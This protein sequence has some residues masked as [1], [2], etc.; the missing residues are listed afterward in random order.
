MFWSHDLLG[1]KTALGAIWIAAHGKKLNKNNIL[2]VNVAEACNKVMDPEVPQ[3]LRL[4]A[5]LVGGIVIVHARQQVYLLE[6]AQEMLRR[7]RTLDS[8][9][10]GGVGAAPR[11]VLKEG[12]RAAREEAITLPLNA[13][14]G[15]MNLG[16]LFPT[17][18]TQALSE[19]GASGA[20]RQ[21]SGDLFVMPSLPD[22]P[23][24]SS[25]APSHQQ[26]RGRSRDAA[27]QHGSGGAG[28]SGARGGGLL[29][30]GADEPDSQ[31]EGLGRY[32]L[33]LMDG[34][35]TFAVPDLDLPGMEMFQLPAHLKGRGGAAP[36]S[37]GGGAEPKP[38]LTDEL[39]PVPSALLG[40]EGF[41]PEGQP[42]VEQ[43]QLPPASQTPQTSEDRSAGARGAAAGARQRGRGAK[44]GRGGPK[45][46]KATVDDIETLQIR[47]WE[48][49]EWMADH[50]DLL[51]PRPLRSLGSAPAG[52]A[53]KAALVA[54][55]ATAAYLP[56]G[57]WPQ[58]LCELFARV[59]TIPTA[60]GKARVKQGKGRAAPGEGEDLLEEQERLVQAG[61]RSG[62]SRDSRR[63]AEALLAPGGGLLPGEDLAGLDMGWGGFHEYGYGE[64]QALPGAEADADQAGPSAFAARQPD[65]GWEGHSEGEE[66][67][68]TERLRA[69][70]NSTQGAEPFFPLG[71]TPASGGPGG[72]LAA[73]GRGGRGRRAS[74]LLRRDSESGVLS[75]RSSER[76]DSR[77]L[78]DLPEGA[79]LA[80]EDLGA[81]LPVVGEEEPFV[82]EQGGSR[83][84][85]RRTGEA[86]EPSAPLEGTGGLT[87][88]ELL[89]ASAPTQAPPGG[90][91][92]DSLN[93]QT[94]AFVGVMHA[95]FQAAEE[96]QRDDGAAT[97]SLLG[98]AERLSRMDAA[99]LFYQALVAR[100]HGFLALEQ[101]QPYGDILLSRGQNLQGGEDGDDE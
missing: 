62:D 56:G 35:E 101:A 78:S 33:E 87:Q 45:R 14:L 76:R 92:S 72:S 5:I 95:R 88:F 26:R 32:D 50:S 75:E 84:K 82:E 4:Q 28:G 41:A 38:Q 67:V 20:G 11:A 48:Y 71:Q 80:A 46:A 100:S 10:G 2:K 1:K 55:P 54:A 69:A 96:Q 23:E 25:G 43:Q 19:G 13:D 27:G 90:P 73:G 60:G 53:S 57:A 40:E 68:E 22:Y 86:E 85:R 59:S 99:K 24:A 39:V 65:R 21:V 47:G 17:F 64:E 34:P 63:S 77:R 49:R 37:S 18:P 70:L 8:G 74:S 29:M 94:L 7:L 6:D 36:A 15:L 16:D 89:E 61:Q 42:E 66:D 98:M 3:A 31:L 52:S 91:L 30:L 83:R 51:V 97:L 9:E 44:W 58:E 81:M 12:N 93:R 79:P